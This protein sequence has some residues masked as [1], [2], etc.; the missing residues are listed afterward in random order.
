MKNKNVYL[1]LYYAV[2]L[3]ILASRQNVE[4][5][6]PLVLRLA[7]VAMVMFPCV[8]TPKA[9][10][11][12]I[13]TMFLTI[14]QFGFA[15][16][17][18]P[19]ML[20][21]YVILTILLTVVFNLQ[22]KA[23][24]SPPL[25]LVLF[26]IYFFLIDTFTAIDNSN[27]HFPENITYCFIL[28]LLFFCF[29]NNNNNN[30]IRQIPFTFAIT[31]IV[32][33]L[34][35]LLNRSL[36]IQD[37][38]FNTGLDRSGWTDPNYFGMVLGMGTTMG[39]IK[40]F[41]TKGEKKPFWEMIVYIAAIVVSIPALILNASRGAIL[42]VILGM[43]TL[44]IFSKVR[45]SYKILIII[46]AVLGIIWLYKNQYFELLEYRIEEDDGTGSKRTEI[47]S[48]KLDLFFK[49]NSFRWLIGYGYTGGLYITGRA[50]GFH[51]EYIAFLVD[52]GI[53]GTLFLFYM[54]LYPLKRVKNAENK[55]A[56]VVLIVYLFTCFLTL[57]PF[58][59]GIPAFYT[60]YLYAI[61]LSKKRSFVGQ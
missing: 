19:Y 40:I 50:L 42:S 28:L 10:Y 47:W 60:F 52:Y 35:F 57:E 18:M 34:Y 48:A 49:G 20:Y 38:G 39:A 3:V 45:I 16:S 36:F 29:I 24:S 8:F 23:H 9:S 12:A 14:S 26:A 30:A 25:F 55:S 27:A 41:E 7:F 15:Y 54:L 11:P 5:E 61:V 31:T 53:I 21:F 17:Y 56:I 37:Y 2:L 13:I 33:S 46:V 4:I 51:N 32:L 6:P 43:A 22:N 1:I 58:S 59:L 44:M